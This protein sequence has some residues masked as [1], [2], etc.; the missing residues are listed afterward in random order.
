ME[1]RLPATGAT[2]MIG[3][4]LT[5]VLHTR[6]LYTRVIQ[7]FSLCGD[8]SS[9]HCNCLGVKGGNWSSLS[10]FSAIAETEKLPLTVYCCNASST[11]V[12]HQLNRPRYFQPL[13]TAATPLKSISG[14]YVWLYHCTLSLGHCA[15]PLLRSHPDRQS[16]NLV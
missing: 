7:P 8:E 9:I 12:Q 10:P 5:R 11:R 4:L 16:F 2:S 3:P 6:V 14:H 1:I 15:H 13:C